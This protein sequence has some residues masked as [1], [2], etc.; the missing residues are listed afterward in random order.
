MVEL[1]IIKTGDHYIRNK[2]GEIFACP[3][4]MAS[5]YTMAQLEVAQQVLAQVQSQGFN[6]VSLRKLTL[7]E[8]PFVPQYNG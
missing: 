7:T 5:V 2:G 6:K 8:E 1:L 3:L 4:E